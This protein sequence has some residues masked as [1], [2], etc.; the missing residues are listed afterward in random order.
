MEKYF[1]EYLNHRLFVCWNR[2]CAYISM[3]VNRYNDS[4]LYVQFVYPKSRLFHGIKQVIELKNESS[5]LYKVIDMVFNHY[6][7]ANTEKKWISA[8][9]F[10][11]DDSPDVYVCS[12]DSYYDTFA[13]DILL[14]KPKRKVPFVYYAF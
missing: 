8:K 3:I 10:K 9:I 11:N 14:H 6:F 5:S 2:L 13:N 4:Y 12:S 1:I 7:S